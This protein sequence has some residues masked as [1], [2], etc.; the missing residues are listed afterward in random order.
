MSARRVIG[1][2]TAVESADNVD[3]SIEDTT[4]LP[5]A[6]LVGVVLVVNAPHATLNCPWCWAWFLLI[7]PV[8]EIAA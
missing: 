5:A 6:T 1:I 4:G 2:G 7:V 3:A 8:E